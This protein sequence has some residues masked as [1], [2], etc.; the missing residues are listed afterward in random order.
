[1]GAPGAGVTPERASWRELASL[2]SAIEGD[3]RQ[4]H[5]KYVRERSALTSLISRVAAT[6]HADVD[7]KRAAG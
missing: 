2:T 6:E 5:A 3:C 4:L 1:V 7:F